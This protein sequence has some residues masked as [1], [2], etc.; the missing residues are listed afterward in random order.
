M[1]RLSL[2][3]LVL[4]C[5]GCS[6]S[7]VD[8][9]GGI[10][11]TVADEITKEP[12]AGVKVSLTPGGTS[13]VTGT[14]GN[15]LFDNIDPQEYTL[16]FTKDDYVSQTQ[17][18]SVKAGTASNVQISME[19]ITPILNVMPEELDFGEETGALAKTCV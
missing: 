16:T 14:E 11:G 4:L 12:L 2:F 10:A 7:E 17:K 15:F 8:T 6:E 18:V 3:L 9:F 5:F 19:P 1:K 13:Q